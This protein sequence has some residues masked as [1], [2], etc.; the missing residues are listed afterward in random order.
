MRPVIIPA[1]EREGESRIRKVRVILS[2][3][4]G[5]EAARLKRMNGSGE[6]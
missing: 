3:Q 6:Q 2:S 5:A 4:E 1:H